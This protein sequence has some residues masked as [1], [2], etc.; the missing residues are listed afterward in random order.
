[1]MN[2]IDVIRRFNRFYT[3]KIGV[4]DRRFD[5]SP[6]GLAEARVLYELDRRDKAVASEISAE[7]GLD[8]AHLSRILAGFARKGLVTRKVASADRRRQFLTLSPKGKI[9][10][11]RLRAGTE[12]RLSAL[13]KPLS[14][15]SQDAL[16]GAMGTIERVLGGE[17]GP[18]TLRD[19]VPGDMGAVIGGQARIYAEEYGWNWEFEGFVAEICGKFIRDFDPKWEKAWIAERDGRVVGSVFC[20]RERK[21]VAKLRMLY[22]DRDARGTGTGARLVDEVIAFAKA[23]KYRRLVLWTND[24]LTAARK[25][26]LARGFVLEKSEKHR[27]FGKALVGQYWS[28]DLVGK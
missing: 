23:K 20:G 19:P 4:F 8:P 21:S 13:L 27:S 3:R 7:L 26:Y 5:G 24:I 1:M 28:L 2:R 6:F 11:R 22:V 25:I 12:K 16:T 9:A 17:A 14:P 10:F 15:A 18:V